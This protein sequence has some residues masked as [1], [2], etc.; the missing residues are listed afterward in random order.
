MLNEFV[1]PRMFGF[2]LFAGKS[3]E[4]AVPVSFL[5]TESGH[6]SHLNYYIVINQVHSQG[7]L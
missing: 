7:T 6:F 2:F 3:E 1:P 4:S 5:K